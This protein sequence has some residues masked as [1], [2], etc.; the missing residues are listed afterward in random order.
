MDFLKYLSLAFLLILVYLLVQ[1]AS[2][3]SKVIGSL[4]NANTN[5]IL[6]LQGRS[7]NASLS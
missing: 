5:A 7:V 1:N 2:G 4:S 3:T 6:A